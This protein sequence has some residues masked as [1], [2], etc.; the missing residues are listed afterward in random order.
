MFSRIIG[1]QQT[2]R[3]SQE[4]V[5]DKAAAGVTALAKLV[6]TVGADS[7]IQVT[8]IQNWTAQ[9]ALQLILMS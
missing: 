9:G 1:S 8:L 3:T 2:E 6:H 7:G 4:Q 5:S